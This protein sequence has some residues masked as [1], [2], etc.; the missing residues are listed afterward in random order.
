VRQNGVEKINGITNLLYVDAQ[1]VPLLNVQ[2]FD[3][4]VFFF[5]FSQSPV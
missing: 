5:D 1:L 3:V 2:G 4:M